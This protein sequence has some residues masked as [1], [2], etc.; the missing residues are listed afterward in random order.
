[1][2]LR[3][4]PQTDNSIRYRQMTSQLVIKNIQLATASENKM[5]YGQINNAAIAIDQGKV[6][7]L[8][9]AS[10]APAGEVEVDGQ[11]RWL[12]PGLIDCHTHLIFGGNRANEFEWRQQGISYSEISNRGGGIMSTVNATRA[13]SDEKLLADAQQRLNSLIEEGV[14]SIEIKSGYGLSLEQELRLLR[15]ARELQRSNNREV[16]TTL[17]AAHAL[18]PEFTSKDEYIAHIVN[19]ILP[20]AANEGLVDAVDVFC[21]GVGFSIAQCERVFTKATTLGLPIKGHVEQLSNLHG[22]A[23]VAKY[24]GLSVDHVEYLTV[25]DIQ[26]L[27]DANT[28]AVLLPAAFFFL[29]ETQQPPIQ[30]LRDAGVAM[31]V[32]TDC[33]PGTAPQASLL[34]AM[35]QAC[36]LFGLTPEESFYGV[37]RHAAAALGLKNKGQLGVGFDA[38][39]LLW[40]IESPAELSYGINLVKPCKRCIGG[41]L[42]G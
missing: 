39:M 12:T 5:P 41:E 37:T 30:A 17:L 31:A 27:K 14:T 19:D 25:Q 4:S 23:L 11:G 21:E 26:L 18:P 33:N 3:H 42:Q 35:N 2:F 8:G 32:A 22:S 28:V 34:A 9:Q 38:D 6:V 36:V 15:L 7:W 40:D 20:A 10:N 16:A 1:M 29:K 24:K 13:A